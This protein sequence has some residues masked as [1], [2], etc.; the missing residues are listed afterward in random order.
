[1]QRRP[2]VVSPPAAELS[3]ADERIRLVHRCRLVAL[4][5]ALFGCS[6]CGQSPP[7]G[8]SLAT[9]T[10]VGNSGLL[11]MLTNRFSEATGIPLRSQLVG[12][13]LALRMLAERHVSVV[14]SH[15]PS[16]E[17][18][19]LAAHPA[20]DYRKIMWNR[21]VVVGPPDDPAG[22]SGTRDIS[23][24]MRRIVSS[25]ATFL[26]RGDSS[27]THEREEELWTRAGVRPP[28]RRLIV[29]GSGMGTTLR[30]ASQTGAYTLTDLATFAQLAPSLSLRIVLEGDPS[31]LNTYAVI[32]D[33]AA[34]DA[35]RAA[36][37]AEWLSEGRGRAEIERF[38]VAGGVKAFTVWPVERPRTHPSDTP[39]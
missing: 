31:L 5:L 6:G 29:A 1:M 3:P 4:V 16:A 21:F 2:G 34:H 30:I 13:G 35:S 26:S 38:T 22:V 18:K 36:A 8:I 39:Y 7:G 14:I 23:D 28:P 20:W 25:E 12:S 19:M 17:Q 9:T 32:V 33:G 10:S 15:A 27:G 37:F 11:E 24:A